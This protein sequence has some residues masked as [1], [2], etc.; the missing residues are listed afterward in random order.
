[1]ENKGEWQK[2]REREKGREGG[3]ECCAAPEPCPRWSLTR[4][5][6]SPAPMWAGRG[7]GRCRPLTALTG[8]WA[9]VSSPAHTHTPQSAPPP[10]LQTWDY[11]C[12]FGSWPCSWRASS[13]PT[14]SGQ[15]GDA[16]AW[17]LCRGRSRGSC[18][19]RAP[20]DRVQHAVWALRDGSGPGASICALHPYFQRQR[21]GMLRLSQES[22]NFGEAGESRNK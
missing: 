4:L 5:C 17:C 19:P 3:L 10:S 16:S 1:M 11:S 2:K 7:C 22:G 6:W 14:D 18:L 13:Q 9:R 8:G 20:P 15:V 21:E 12:C